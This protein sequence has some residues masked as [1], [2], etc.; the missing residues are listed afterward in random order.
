MSAPSDDGAPW[1]VEATGDALEVR[2]EPGERWWG[3]A[4]ADGRLMPFGGETHSRD[5]GASAG[6]G[7]QGRAGANQCAPLLLST[8]GR[9][10]WS[11][12]P[13]AF[14]VDEGRLTL[15]GSEIVLGRSGGTLREA[16]LAA[17]SRFFP[18][19]GRSPAPELFTG[20]QYNSWIQ[21]PWAPT[22][23]GVL[24]Y[25][26]ELLDDGMPPGVVMVDDCWSPGYGTWV[27]DQ[28]RFPDPAAMVAQLHAWGCSLMLWVVP[29]VSPD[30]AV[31]RDLDARG[32]LLRDRH[33]RTALRSWWNGWS[34]TLDV[35]D[36]DAVGWLCE[37]L[38]AL[39][40]QTGV[41]GFK[42]DAGDVV[43]YRA[44]DLTAGRAEPVDMCE[45][46]ARIG[47]RYPFNEYR[48]CW[49]M[50]GQ[51]LAQRLHDKPPSWGADG[52]G[53]L[54]PELVAQGLLGHAFTCPDMVGGGEI[55]AVEDAGAVDQ[56]FFVR[57]AQVAALAPMMQFSLSPSR[58]LDE[59]HRA[60]VADA[61]RVRQEHVPLL[62]DLVAH[63]ARTGEPVVRA[64]AYHHPGLE[65][66]VDQFMLGRSL[67]V[68][69][70]VE[71][72]SRHRRVH[73][74]PGGWQGDDGTRYQGP[75][76]VTVAAPLDRLPRFRLLEEPPAS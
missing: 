32:L 27:F 58:V 23:E 21:M 57:S 40:E 65:D 19:S 67:V 41:D 60:A 31:F 4:V 7:P 64:M 52:I 75:D 20:P 8:S 2:L 1:A 25:V 47:L 11:E 14:T 70:V 29:F 33:G 74:P 46:W 68:A 3:G 36:P 38:D 18:P 63:A 72:G 24:A 39:V 61:V 42:L 54:V 37:Q 26:R 69:P 62:E 16:F 59:Q 51:P 17:S 35:S 22:Q 13:F 73:L 71:A 10:V 15:R 28:G 76:V 50:G 55:G 53:S 66:V 45:A 12:R 5:L 30:S 48:A 44:D 43:D 6:T 49:R 34:A 56:E 9:V